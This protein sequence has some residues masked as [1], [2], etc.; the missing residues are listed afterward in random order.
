MSL[1]MLMTPVPCIWL[2]VF[3]I[4]FFRK[5]RYCFS[6]CLTQLPH[7]T[8]LPSSLLNR[9]LLPILLSSEIQALWHTVESQNRFSHKCPHLLLSLRASYSSYRPCYRP[10][11]C[12]RPSCSI[13]T[14][15]ALSH[16]SKTD[17]SIYT[18][19]RR[20]NLPLGLYWSTL[21][22]SP[23]FRPTS[24]ILHCTC[25]SH[26]SNDHIFLAYLAPC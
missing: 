8:T 12:V 11:R 20:F 23:V 5:D 21:T 1:V 17:T 18:R 24:W 14:Y 22:S 9:K 4:A 13:W 15:I 16:G 2:V 25:T 6:S 19:R 10:S 7:H 3:A 26:M